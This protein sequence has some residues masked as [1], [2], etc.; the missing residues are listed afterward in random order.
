MSQ[1]ERTCLALFHVAERR[2]IGPRV[3]RVRIVAE[4]ADGGIVAEPIDRFDRLHV[5]RPERIIH[6]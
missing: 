3:R 1:T 4:L 6:R 5:L 2:L